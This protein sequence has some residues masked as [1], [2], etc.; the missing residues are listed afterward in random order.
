MRT[1]ALFLMLAIAACSSPTEPIDQRAVLAHNRSVW[2]AA[3]VTHYRF[4]LLRGCMCQPESIGPVVIE[5]RDG[6]IVNRHYTTGASVDPQ[7]AELFTTIPGLFDLVETALDLQAA[8]VAVRY[9]RKMG[10]P[11]TIQIDWVAGTTD[12][13]VSYRVSEFT[14]LEP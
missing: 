14:E 5:V 12:D 8:G 1:P 13:E 11:E 3:G 10:Y 6:D 2:Q 4:S 9:H 7:F